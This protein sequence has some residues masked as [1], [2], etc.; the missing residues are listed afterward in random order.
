[1]ILTIGGVKGGCG[2]S[3]VSIGLCIRRARDARVLLVDADTQCTSSD[4]TLLRNETTG[5]AGYTCVQLTGTAVRNEVMRL[6]EHYDDVIIDV[7]GRDTAG[8]RAAISVSDQL[9]IPV[10]PRAF[11]V[12][13]LE[14]FAKLVEDMRPT[15]PGLQVWTFLNRKEH[16]GP[17]NDEA[18]ASWKRTTPSITSRSPSVI[19]KSTGERPQWGSASRSIGRGTPKR[20]RSWRNYTARRLISDNIYVY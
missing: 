3:T 2:K 19:A 15:N 1:M 7:A 8:Q 18:I 17:D 16:S 4:F 20:S 10:V 12:W 5:D 11:D 9:I 6:Q 13:T 14:A